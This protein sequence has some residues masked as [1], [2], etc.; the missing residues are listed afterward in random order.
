MN[1]ELLCDVAIGAAVVVIVGYTLSEVL[2]WLK[3]MLLP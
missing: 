3:G 2:G 1:N